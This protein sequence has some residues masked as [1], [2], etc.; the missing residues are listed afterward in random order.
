MAQGPRN[1]AIFLVLLAAGVQ[2]AAGESFLPRLIGQFET[3]S[4]EG[5]HL[6]ATML[7]E[8]A[9]WLSSRVFKRPASS[10]EA[11]TKILAES[12]ADQ[13]HLAKAQHLYEKLLDARPA[14]KSSADTGDMLMR[15]GDL[16]AAQGRVD[17]ASTLYEQAV[18]ADEQ[19]LPREDTR[20][21]DRMLQVGNFYAS[22]DKPEKAERLY[23]D[24]LSRRRD[25]FGEQDASVSDAG[26]VLA[27]FYDTRGD[28]KKAEQYYR[29]ALASQELASGRKERATGITS[30]LM[31]RFYDSHGDNNAARQAYMRGAGALAKSYGVSLRDLPLLDGEM[32]ADFEA[33]QK[34]FVDETGAPAAP[35]AIAEALRNEAEAYVRL[36]LPAPARR[37]IEQ[38]VSAHE[39]AL[40]KDHPG[41]PQII[42]EHADLLDQIGDKES[43]ELLRRRAWELRSATGE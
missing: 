30:I 27:D 18:Q 25:V 35:L 15:L 42:A 7:G 41:L 2:A 16:H 22:L 3:A 11:M 37:A 14:G 39:R 29:L 38:S 8:S 43:A 33:M 24:V 12:Y 20:L 5:R 34:A 4:R 32:G 26:L 21:T 6:Q 40:G 36:K 28:Q 9:L 17:K 10:D 23:L 19:A 13:K 31:A 1:A